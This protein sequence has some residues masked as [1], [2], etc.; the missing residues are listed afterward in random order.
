MVCFCSVN[1]NSICN[2]LLWEIILAQH[3]ARI[4]RERS[5][6]DAIN[7]VSV[8]KAVQLFHEARKSVISHFIIRQNFKKKNHAVC[9]PGN[10]Q[11]DSDLL[12]TM[13]QS[14]SLMWLWWQTH[15]R[16][17]SA[18]QLLWTCFQGWVELINRLG[19]LCRPLPFGSSTNL[20]MTSNGDIW[21]L[22]RL[23]PPKPRAESQ[24]DL[25]YV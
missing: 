20:W 23:N 16:T 18:L 11:A 4:H 10:T 13:S 17:P 15:W 3:G 12:F 25:S 7:M 5:K 24:L 9:K 14:L 22:T 6:P 2:A 8:R 19:G 1:I 21:H